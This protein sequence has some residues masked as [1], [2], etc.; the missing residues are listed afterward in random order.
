MT[1]SPER[2][3]LLGANGM[4]GS[5]I[6]CL[7][8]N[9]NLTAFDLPDF[10]ITDKNQLERAL[11]KADIVINC[12]AYTNV[13]KAETESEQAFKVNAEAVGNLA[14]LARKNNVYVIHISTDFVFDGEKEA[15][16]LETDK[17]NPINVYGKS[18]LDGETLLTKNHNNFA[19]IRV[20]WTYGK[21]GTNFIA[22]LVSLAKQK[23]SLKV[24]NDQFGSP[25]STQEA[26]E[27]IVE[28]AV[29]KPQGL[30]H[31]AAAGFAS[32][33]DAAKFTFE[34]L[35]LNAKILPCKSN[36]F[37]TAAKRPLNSRFCCDKIQALLDKPIEEWQ[38][39][40]ERFL[41]TIQ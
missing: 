20:Q 25:T 19:I 11:E 17:P 39:P 27:A 14:Q 3:V 28:L 8:D 24:V 5:E 1:I 33:Y 32:R 12:T 38:K 4:L 23:D 35:K 36:E 13:E 22:K 16:Y 10:D 6:R 2:I 30:F 26:A 31:Y 21:N 37:P 34:K 7:C 29:K 18:K 15:P 9:D 41:K 40:L